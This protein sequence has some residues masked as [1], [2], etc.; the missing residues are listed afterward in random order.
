YLILASAG[1]LQ[2]GRLHCVA[3]V[4]AVGGL[5]VITFVALTGVNYSSQVQKEDWRGAM[6]YLQDHTR[7][8]DA[9]VV[10]PGYLVTA[11]NTYYKPGGS[12]QVPNV[13]IETVP[14]LS[15]AHFGQRELESTLRET[16][17][18]H[19][20]IWLVTSPPRQ[21]QEDPENRVQQWFQYN[22]NT[23]DTR[24]FNGVSLYGISFNSQV[25]CWFPPPDYPEVHTYTNGLI[26]QGYI[27]ELRH[28]ATS[29]MDAS[30]FPLTM[31]WHN[32]NKLDAD[33]MVRVR[34]KSPSG[35]YIVD[36]ALRPLNGYTKT[37]EWPPGRETIDYR[38]IRL[39]GG[40]TPGNYTISLQVY[41]T[42]H[43]EKALSLE[44]GSTEFEFKAPLPVIPW[45][46]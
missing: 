30:Y 16:I 44:D 17:N 10:F 9:I 8:R 4:A 14:S 38:D 37:S 12:G 19:E 40:L 7:L 34:I 23:F 26:F 22:W 35:L 18:C 42:G 46:P 32:N 24:V 36:E 39:P 6:S 2:L 27:Y 41:P 1:L 28:D 29:Q 3:M 45:K 33:Y 13:P 15:T 5:S 31:Y 25:N 21:A 20:R 43:P 11:V